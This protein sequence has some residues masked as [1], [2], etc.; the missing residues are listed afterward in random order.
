MFSPSA[1]SVAFQQGFFP[2]AVQS[3]V[4]HRN[5]AFDEGVQT[6]YG[7][8]RSPTSTYEQAMREYRGEAHDPEELPLG[9]L[10][11]MMLVAPKKRGHV[12]A[13]IRLPEL[14][15]LRA[16]RNPILYF[17]YRTMLRCEKVLRNWRV[18]TELRRDG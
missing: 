3:G 9:L 10:W 11:R 6:A 14:D 18:L 15:E 16:Y 13:Q 17:F 8:E 7:G 2:V 4:D 5:N 12:N 1:S